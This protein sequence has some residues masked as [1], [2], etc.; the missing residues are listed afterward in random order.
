MASAIELDADN[1]TPRSDITLP[2]PQLTNPL[3]SLLLRAPLTPT[4]VCDDESEHM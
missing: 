2:S 4:G 3:A 1:G